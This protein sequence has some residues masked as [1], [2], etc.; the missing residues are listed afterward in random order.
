MFS[1]PMIN[2]VVTMVAG[3][4]FTTRDTV[5]YE[6]HDDTLIGLPDTYKYFVSRHLAATDSSPDT[7]SSHSRQILI[8]IST[9]FKSIFVLIVIYS[10]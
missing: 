1:T 9:Y 5:K 8:L 2:E 4:Q 6:V 7:S 3:E 10:L